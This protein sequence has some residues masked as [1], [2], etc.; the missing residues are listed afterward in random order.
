MD[1]FACVEL[2]YVGIYYQLRMII[3][4]RFEL[5]EFINGMDQFICTQ[6]EYVGIHFENGEYLFVWN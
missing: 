4:M 5:H 1:L 6:L 2:E 3:C